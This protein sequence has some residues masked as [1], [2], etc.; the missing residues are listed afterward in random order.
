MSIFIKKKLEKNYF[1]YKNSNYSV[2][3]KMKNQ[4][5]KHKINLELNKLKF[6]NNIMF[7]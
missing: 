7:Q 2:N 3:H 4:K 6:E 5:H 1:Y